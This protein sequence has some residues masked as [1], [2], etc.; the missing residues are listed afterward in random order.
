MSLGFRS[1]AA[2][3]LLAACACVAHP[4]APAGRNDAAELEHFVLTLD[5][6]THWYESMR[7]LE[8]LAKA[9]PGIASHF[10][11]DKDESI[12]VEEQ[13]LQGDPDIVRTLARHGLTLH[14][15]V[16]VERSYFPTVIAA[17]MALK[18]KV[19]P[20]HMVTELHLNPA[21]LAFLEQHRAELAA[22][23]RKY[24]MSDD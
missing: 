3:M 1:L 23:D 18:L 10:R 20:A 12:A 9:K 13:G 24:P 15:C 4:S 16:L 17:S 2:L 19:D 5:A 8:Q 22:L 7:D 11:G 6:V 21:N 14:L